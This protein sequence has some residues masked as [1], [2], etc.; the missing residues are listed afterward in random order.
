MAEMQCNTKKLV[1][2]VDQVGFEQSL[3]P[4]MAIPSKRKQSRVSRKA[5]IAAVVGPNLHQAFF[6]D[7]VN[8]GFTLS[9]FLVGVG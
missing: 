6:I 1:S 8:C 7:L 2:K 5:A 3:V 9:S 4:F